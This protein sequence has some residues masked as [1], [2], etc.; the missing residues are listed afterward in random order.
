MTKR[1]TDRP[2]NL[3]K[4]KG[5]RTSEPPSPNPDWAPLAA[6]A[7]AMKD[8]FEALDKLVVGTVNEVGI[9]EPLKSV[10]SAVDTPRDCG[11]ASSNAVS[12]LTN[13]SPLHKNKPCISGPSGILYSRLTNRGALIHSP[14]VGS[15]EPSRM[16][17]PEQG[18]SQTNGASTQTV[19]AGGAES[20]PLPS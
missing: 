15:K 17:G 9:I 20:R 3:R 6:R 14:A 5:E 12:R 10:G 2:S 11:K 1:V 4:P 19:F 8:F 16:L 7:S 13:I 18:G